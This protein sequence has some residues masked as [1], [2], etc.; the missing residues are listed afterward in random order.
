[1]PL[2]KTKYLRRLK[3]GI[4]RMTSPC[5]QSKVHTRVVPNSDIRVNYDKNLD[6]LKN[7]LKVF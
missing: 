4:S 2:N 3:L 1:M 7:G 6:Q 5:T